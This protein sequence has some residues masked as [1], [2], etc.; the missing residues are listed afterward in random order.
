MFKRNPKVGMIVGAPHWIRPADD[1]NQPLIG[2]MCQQLGVSITERS[3]FM[4]GTIFWIRWEVLRQFLDQSHVQLKREYDRC[5]LGYLINNKPTFMHSW[6]RIFGYIVHHYGYQIA[7]TVHEPLSRRLDQSGRQLIAKVTY[8]LNPNS[9]QCVDVTD[10]VK[11]HLQR[12]GSLYFSQIQT[13]QEWGDPYPEKR[14]QVH[15]HMASEYSAPNTPGAV[16]TLQEFCGGVTP[17]YYVL[18]KGDDPSEIVLQLKQPNNWERSITFRHD[19]PTGHIGTY[20]TT[21]FDCAYYAKQYAPWLRTP[22]Y[23]ECIA[24][25]IQYGRGAN[26]ATFEPGC[27][28]CEKYRIQLWA[29]YVTHHHPEWWR[30]W[31]PLF[32]GSLSPSP[33]AGAGEAEVSD[34]DHFRH[35][36]DAARLYGIHGFCLQH[37]WDQG[38]KSDYQLAEALLAHDTPEFNFP[39]CFAWETITTASDPEEW[40][41]HFQYLLPFFQDH[42]YLCIHPH[43]PVIRITSEALHPTFVQTWKTLATQAGLAGLYIIEQYTTPP[44]SSIPLMGDTILHMQPDYGI[45]RFPQEITS[46]RTYQT[47]NYYRLCQAI[48]NDHDGSSPLPSFR[49]VWVGYDNSAVPRTPDKLPIICQHKTPRG[50]ACALQAQLEQILQSP[51]PTSASISAPNWIWIHAWNDWDHQMV[52]ENDQKTLTLLRDVLWQYQNPQKYNKLLDIIL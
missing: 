31:K 32:K 14:K 19:N 6:E 21:F 20:A 35:Q 27:N 23:S 36:I 43:V 49:Q 25:Y 29:D 42:R 28:L 50:I 26:L 24:H 4:A 40:K 9:D 18:A 15:L 10:K 7:S 46:H 39:F 11:E 52:L 33:P 2:Q 44:T 51:T 47:V 1:V 13:N 41:Q 8:G 34:L 30:A 22:T 48:N 37:T 38:Y 45:R 12:T 3:Q 16:I 17:N 5:E